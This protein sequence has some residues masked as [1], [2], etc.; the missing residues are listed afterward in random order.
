MVIR[1]ASMDATGYRDGPWEG[2]CARPC[3]SH[4]VRFSSAKNGLGGHNGSDKGKTQVR[5]ESG[6]LGRRVEAASGRDKDR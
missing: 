2:Y 1:W 4:A 6:T 3:L 5:G